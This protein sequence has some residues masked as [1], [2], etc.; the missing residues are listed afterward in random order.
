MAVDRAD[1][2]QRLDALPVDS[3]DADEEVLHHG[4]PGPR[5]TDQSPGVVRDDGH[6]Q[7]GEQDQQDIRDLLEPAAARHR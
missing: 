6:E 1:E 5:V 2:V 4:E 3:A 7:D